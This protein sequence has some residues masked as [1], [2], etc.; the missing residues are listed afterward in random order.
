MST[1]DQRALFYD[2]VGTLPET[3]VFGFREK[4][5]RKAETLVAAPSVIQLAK[6]AWGF[7]GPYCAP[8]C[9]CSWETLSTASCE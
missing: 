4:Y 5:S 2:L 8:P 9:G 1:R 7:E 3:K 6:M